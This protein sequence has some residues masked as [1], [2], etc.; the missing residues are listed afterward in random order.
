MSGHP[1]RTNMVFHGGAGHC[2]KCGDELSCLPGCDRCMAERGERA[3]VELE[4]LKRGNRRFALLMAV[5]TAVIFIAV[6]VLL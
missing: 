6:L 1:M 3:R 5:V 2:G 4:K